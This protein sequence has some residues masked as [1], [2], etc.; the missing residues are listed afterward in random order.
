MYSSHENIN[1]PPLNNVSASHSHYVPTTRQSVQKGFIASIVTSDL[2]LCRGKAWS[3]EAPKGQRFKLT[4]FDFSLNRTHANGSSSSSLSGSSYSPTKR[5]FVNNVNL[6]KKKQIQLGLPNYKRALENQQMSGSVPPNNP[7]NLI[8][9]PKNL[10]SSS[11]LTLLNHSKAKKQQTI[12]S[13]RVYNE[14]LPNAGTFA[15]QRTRPLNSKLFIRPLNK[16]HTSCNKYLIVQDGSK[17]LSVCGQQGERVAWEHVSESHQV[18]VWVTAGTA[19]NDLSR[20]L[21]EFQGG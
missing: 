2:P 17:N 3:L 15:A 20:F 5:L 4:L 9:S 19:S 8:S 1:S 6:K 21:L 13:K 12:Q 7:P 10:R 18:K 14:E 16:L 11:N